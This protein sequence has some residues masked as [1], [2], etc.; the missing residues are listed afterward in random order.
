M[1]YNKPRAGSVNQMV[2]IKVNSATKKKLGKPGNRMSHRSQHS[3]PRVSYIH[4]GER[5]FP[6][7]SP[8]TVLPHCMVRKELQKG[9][10]NWTCP[11]TNRQKN[12]PGNSWEYCIARAPDPQKT[13]H[14][15]TRPKEAEFRFWKISIHC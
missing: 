11:E 9:S 4:S 3:N 8:A 15:K 2:K 12:T 5:T 7:A 6:T 14:T 13:L 10:L 1:Q